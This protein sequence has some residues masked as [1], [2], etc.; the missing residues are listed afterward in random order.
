M[1]LVVWPHVP[2]EGYSSRGGR[3]E[4]K[5]PG[6]TVPGG[7]RYTP[8]PYRQIVVAIEAG[9]TNPTGIHSCLTIMNEILLILPT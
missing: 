3:V 6:G 1:L 4:G 8:A 9:G 5:V 7:F 2:L